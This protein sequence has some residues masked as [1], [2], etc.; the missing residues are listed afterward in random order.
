[1][2]LKDIF[3]HNNHVETM[4]RIDMFL[5]KITN[6]PSLKALITSYKEIGTKPKPLNFHYLIQNVF[7]PLRLRFKIVL[8]IAIFD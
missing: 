4:T 6:S 8:L 2:F 1:M 7:I 5:S 3:I